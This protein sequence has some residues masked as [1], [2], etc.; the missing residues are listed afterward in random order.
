MISIVMYLG[1]MNSE[2]ATELVDKFEI[3]N[4]SDLLKLRK[5]DIESVK[6]I[7]FKTSAKLMRW[8]K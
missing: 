1:G 4:L 6:G 2:K 8:L 7:G 5:K 3:D